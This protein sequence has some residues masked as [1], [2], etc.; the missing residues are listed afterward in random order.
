MRDYH[1]RL[2]VAGRITIVSRRLAIMTHI[3]IRVDTW[4]ETIL[5]IWLVLSIMHK[6]ISA[7]NWWVDRLTKVKPER[8]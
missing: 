6:V 2:K 7:A 3:T 1:L 8:G 5:A 4:F